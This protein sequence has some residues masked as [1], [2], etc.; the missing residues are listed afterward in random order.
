MDRDE[1]RVK[2][3]LEEHKL[4]A[5]RY[6]KAETRVWKTPDFRVFQ[7]EKLLFYCEVKSSPEDRWLDDQLYNAS[8]GELVGGVRNDS[9]FNRLSSDIHEAVKQFDAVNKDQKY[10]NVLALVNHDDMCGF[11]DLLGIL[12][13][14][15]YAN[16]GTVY[17]IYRQFSHGRIKDEKGRI[18]LFIRLDDNKP[19]RLLFSQTDE[20]HHAA[21]CTAFGVQLNEIKQI[22]S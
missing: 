15:F 11:N 4:T 8:P 22:S 12:T 14:N 3:Y 13:G 18:H 21:L 17:P 10:P 9:I 7:H 2:G 19:D 16:D 20:G 6:S 5:K 1:E